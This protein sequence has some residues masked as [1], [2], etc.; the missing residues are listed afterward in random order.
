MRRT[1]LAGAAA[2][3]LALTLTL[4]ACGSQEDDE[5]TGGSTSSTTAPAEDLVITVGEGGITPNG[6]RIKLGIGEEFTFTIEAETEGSFH[7]H[8]TPEQEV[9]YSP[10][11]SEHTLSF[12]RP[13]VVEM[14]SH[15]P[16]LVIVQFQVS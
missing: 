16:S 11:T 3:A 10:G 15:D 2:A 12:D 1:A 6:E 14:E 7:V 9:A 4:S 8:S 13:G 5:P